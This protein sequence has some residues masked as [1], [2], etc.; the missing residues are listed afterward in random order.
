MVANAFVDELGR[1]QTCGMEINQEVCASPALGEGEKDQAGHTAT[2]T[3]L[4]EHL[5]HT[6][7]TESM[8]MI[9]RV[10]RTADS[11]SRHA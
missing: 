3:D 2:A 1:V 6:Q 9:F 10:A 7:H 11:T 8:R 4:A 5:V